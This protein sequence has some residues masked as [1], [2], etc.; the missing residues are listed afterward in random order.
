MRRRKLSHIVGTIVVLLFLFASSAIA[1]TFY[2]ASNSTSV[3]SAAGLCKVPLTTAYFDDT[4]ENGIT[5]SAQV[6]EPATVALLGLGALVL[7]S[8][9]RRGRRK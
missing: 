1:A 8:G 2:Q 9:Q 3:T 7:I 6:P 4:A 5:T